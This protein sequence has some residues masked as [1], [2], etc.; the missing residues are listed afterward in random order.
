MPDYSV[1]N[2]KGQDPHV[3]HCTCPLPGL[4]TLRIRMT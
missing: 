1:Q 2:P 4:Q 3:G